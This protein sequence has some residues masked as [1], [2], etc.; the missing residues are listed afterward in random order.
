ME[1]HTV[2]TIGR[3]RVNEANVGHYG[4]EAFT[5][6]KQG[7]IVHNNTYFKHE[8]TL[9]EKGILAYDKISR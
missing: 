2:V 9:S 4:R 3:N 7:F 1:G 6:I 5:S 8:E